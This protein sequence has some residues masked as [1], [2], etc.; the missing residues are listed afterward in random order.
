MPKY[1]LKGSEK[2]DQKIDADMREIFEAVSASEYAS[3]YSALILLGGYGRGEGTPFIN[4]EGR[5]RDPVQQPFNDY[6]LVVV[7]ERLNDEIRADLQGF[8]RALS[9]KLGL[10]VD[11]YPY[12]RRD[13]P[14]CEFSLLNYEL[15]YGHMVVWGDE[16]ILDAMPEYKHAELP[17]SEGMRLLL[18]RGKLLLDIKRRLKNDSPLSASERI[19]FLKFFFKEMLAFGDCAL[20]INNAYDLSYRKKKTLIEN[21]DMDGL[22]A[23]AEIVASYK[24]AIDFKEWGDF[25]LLDDIDIQTEFERVRD[26]FIKFYLWYEGRRLSG[27]CARS[28]QHAHLLFQNANECNWLKALAYNLSW[29]RKR[30]I[31]MSVRDLFSHPRL[32]MYVALPL[33]LEKDSDIERI[34]EILFLSGKDFEQASAEFYAMQKRYS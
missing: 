10:P 18:N 14:N 4:Y 22:S 9:D 25:R 6:D 33:L 20:L 7:V 17:L 19:C 3:D 30:A 5:E 1:T 29:L 34:D 15:K 16:H 26:L 11:L 24:R 32:R 23:S 8:E 31:G 12:L 27:D 28:E 2:L 13:L 21:V